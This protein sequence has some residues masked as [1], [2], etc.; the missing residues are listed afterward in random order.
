MSCFEALTP[1]LL[2]I[3]P[4]S[5]VWV[6]AITSALTMSQQ[7]GSTADPDDAD[8]ISRLNSAE[9]NGSIFGHQCQ[10]LCKTALTN[11]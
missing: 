11:E 5:I 7:I 6:I 8:S 3:I 10:T 1:H 4:Y 9:A 2:T